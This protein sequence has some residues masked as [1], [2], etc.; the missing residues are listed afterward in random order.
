MPEVTAAVVAAAEAF[1]LDPGSVRPLGGTSGSAWGIGGRVLRIGRRAGLDAE[2][3]AAA[4]AA[5]AVPVPRVIDRV[6]VGQASAVLLE[7]LP[8]RP[9]MELAAGEPDLARAAGRSC[10]ALH[11]RLAAVPAPGG[12]REVPGAVGQHGRAGPG[13]LLHLDL[14]PLNV[15]VDPSGAVTG[16]VDW[17]NAAAGDPVLDRAR[18]WAILTLDP[19]AR[20]QREPG[21]TA[22]AE[23]WAE[24]GQLS[25]IPA[26]ARAW[27]CRFM[28]TDLARRYQPGELQHVADALEIAEAAAR[29]SG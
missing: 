27:A 22:L 8:G 16:V 9:A 29:D 13:R 12:L 26:A 11:A 6:E 5:A 3:A 14:H 2:V 21:W 7:M 23:G 19:Q 28:L 4:A 18:T 25:D 15:L 10:G 24:S 17:A 20:R 1:G